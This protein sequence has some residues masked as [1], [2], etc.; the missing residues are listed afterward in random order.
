MKRPKIFAS[1]TPPDSGMR[2]TSS[3]ESSERLPRP[4]DLARSSTGVRQWLSVVGF[5][6]VAAAYAPLRVFV[7]NTEKFPHPERILVVFGGLL[8]LGLFWYTCFRLLRFDSRSSL[9]AGFAFT[10]LFSIGGGLAERTTTPAAAGLVMAGSIIVGLLS[11]R[12]GSEFAGSIVLIMSI[13]IGLQL[14]VT[15]LLS[16]VSELGDSDVEATSSPLPER[17]S[18][19]PDIY[20]ILLDGFPGE[21][22]A[23]EIYQSDLDLPD[24]PRVERIDAWASY[25]MTTAS[26]ASLL[27]MGYPLS[28][29][30]IVDNSS[31]GDLAQI[32]AGEN[33]FADLLTEEGYRTTLV[34][35][36]YSNSYCAESVDM[37][38]ESAFLDEGIFGIV[39]QTVLTRQL[40]TRRGSAFTENGLHGM[41]WL[42]D[43]LPSMAENN[44]PDYVFAHVLLPHPPLMLDENCVLTYDYWRAGNSIYAGEAIL[45]ARQ[46]AFLDQARCVAD[47]EAELF[48]LLPDDAVV[49]F[50]SDHGGD[51]LGQMSTY[52]HTWSMDDVIERMNAHLAFRSPIPCLLE[53]PVLL[54]E[55]LHDLLWCLAGEESPELREGSRIHTASRIPGTAFYEL[56][57]LSQDRM[58]QLDITPP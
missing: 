26:V 19:R 18:S 32:M 25:P 43:N 42:K 57:E 50:F 53:P 12:L 22:A 46:Q 16:A 2:S 24:I 8:L 49:M 44:Q 52:G 4:A 55:I 38:V 28:E 39:D 5:I 34:E 9:A 54:P 7:V 35:S 30:D 29:G 6:S 33:R 27:Q 10:V 47:F 15:G 37:C 3:N 23:R 51:S 41:T 40:R 31:V 11:S 21:I 48:G 20:L 13:F 17:I 56:S 45:D 14:T 1:N 58:A 36:G